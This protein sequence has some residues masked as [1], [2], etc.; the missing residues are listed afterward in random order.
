MAGW[1]SAVV[2]VALVAG[3]AAADGWHAGVNLRTELGAHSA[4]VDAGVRRGAFD[5]IVVLDPMVVTDGE[6]DVDLVATRT[7]GGSGYGV[8]LG[9]R[10]A[11][12]GLAE[13]RQFQHSALVG[14]VGPLPRIGPLS[15][16]WGV[17]LAAVLVKHGG[18]LPMDRLSLES[19]SALGD[20]F[21]ANM[22]LRI[23]YAAE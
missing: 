10:P 16:S 15:V 9:W 18:G 14:A 17:E 4:R 7:I 1:M 5:F 13:G 21:N 3:P 12:I 6:L 20:N 22:F 8:L 19:M 11:S 23:G 2:V